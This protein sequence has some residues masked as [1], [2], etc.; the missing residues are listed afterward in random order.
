[1]SNLG[2]DT[3]KFIKLSQGANCPLFVNPT[4]IVCFYRSGISDGS[5]LKLS[6]D[7]CYVNESIE[8]IMELING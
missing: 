7:E 2:R 6:N 4:Q 8:E 1:M 5:Y 3:P